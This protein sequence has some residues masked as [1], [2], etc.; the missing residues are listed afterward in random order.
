MTFKLDLKVRFWHFWMNRNSWMDL[1][2]NP[3]SMLILGKKSWFF[4]HTIFKIP[5]PN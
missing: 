3:L 1:K 4:G 2:K 5:Q